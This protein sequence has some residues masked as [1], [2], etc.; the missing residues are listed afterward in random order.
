MRGGGGSC[1][2]KVTKLI[3]VSRH[4][5]FHS[6]NLG[7]PTSKKDDLFTGNTMKLFLVSL[8]DG[9]SL[10]SS[11]CRKSKFRRFLHFALIL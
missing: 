10:R 7:P 4:K 2:E 8:D 9:P 3:G 6:E 5:K 11:N 1:L